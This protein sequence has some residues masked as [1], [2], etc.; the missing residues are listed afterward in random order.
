MLTINL[1]IE[2]PHSNPETIEIIEKNIVL[3]RYA[4]FI[5]F[6]PSRYFQ[7][8]SYHLQH[9]LLQK[10]KKFCNNGRFIIRYHPSS[11]MVLYK[12]SDNGILSTDLFCLREE[13]MTLITLYEDIPDYQ[14]SGSWQESK[15]LV[16]N[17][18][19]SVNY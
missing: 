11:K 9:V 13:I 15:L 16:R 7:A 12:E 14:A 17:L 1:D 5:L 2:L 19:D 6:E 3:P 4:P 10:E 18:S 8:W